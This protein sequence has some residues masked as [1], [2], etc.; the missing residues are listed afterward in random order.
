M[1]SA[2]VLVTGS[3][4]FTGRY[5]RQ[6]LE[7]RGYRVVG[8]CSL[9]G[10]DPGQWVANLT[11]AESLRRV[12]QKLQPNYVIHL[13]AIAFVGHGDPRAFYDIN[14]F[15]TLNLMSALQDL[16]KLERVVVASSANVYGTPEV[17]LIDESVCPNPVNH[18]AC[19]KWAMEQMLR[20][21][22]RRLP[23]VIVRPFNYTGVG[24]DLQFLIPKIVA[25]FRRKA[26]T[27]ELGNLDVA[28][29]FSDVRDVAACYADLLQ[30]S[31]ATGQTLNICSG[32]AYALREVL[33]MATEITG[34]HLDVRMN[35]AFVR[36][37][38]V[39]R[40]LG[41]ADRL[42]RCIGHSPSTPLR[43][44]LEWMFESEELG[45]VPVGGAVTRQRALMP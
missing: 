4:G 26:E 14:L 43:S 40:L 8:L 31:D 34:H 22:F 32:R 11:D 36:A 29:D 37:N 35:P 42:R 5:L 6:V 12:V 15:G 33:E 28:R 16:P 41:N 9:A 23:L 45:I 27:V 30:A 25:H 21:S 3:T 38:E 24:Q 18:Y 10:V 1:E 20:S 44:V 17:E 13:A 19:S 2:T 39:P 7:Q